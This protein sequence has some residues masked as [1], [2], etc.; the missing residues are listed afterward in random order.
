MGTNRRKQNM[1][2]VDE[3]RMTAQESEDENSK[4]KLDLSVI[5]S[6]EMPVE[7][8]LAIRKEAG[9]KIDPEIAE[10]MWGYGQI[11]DPYGVNPDLPDEASC[12]GRVYFARSPGSDIWVSFYDLPG[13]TCKALWQK[14][15]S[16]LAFSSD[17]FEDDVPF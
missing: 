14:H 8:W 1:T 7:Q 2:D 11:L 13:D 5:D 15:N 12:I 16:K 4:E 9:L 10:V 6:D 17:P 3:K